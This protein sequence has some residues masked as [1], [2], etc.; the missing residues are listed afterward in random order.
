[1]KISWLGEERRGVVVAEAD[2]GC[3]K[4]ISPIQ[5]MEMI[6]KFRCA[7]SQQLNKSREK[8]GA[9]TSS[10]AAHR[11]RHTL[12]EGDFALSVAHIRWQHR[13][14]HRGVGAVVLHMGRDRSLHEQVDTD[15]QWVGHGQGDRVVEIGNHDRGGGN[16]HSDVVAD[17]DDDSRHGSVADILEAEGDDRNIHFPE[18]KDDVPVE[19]SGNGRNDR[20]VESH[21]AAMTTVSRWTITAQCKVGTNIRHAADCSTFEFI[22]V[23]L[24]DCNLQIGSSLEFNKPDSLLSATVS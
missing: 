6:S 10:V 8:E 23:K 16:R 11:I 18:G 9:I 2:I 15:L 14:R 7:T 21:P 24:V 4:I 1:M 19:E 22:V 20:C 12:S 13:G 17:Y 3:S 5:L